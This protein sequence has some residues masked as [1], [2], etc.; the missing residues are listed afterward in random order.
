VRS[1]LDRCQN[2]CKLD[3]QQR[4]R[5]ADGAQSN[6]LDSCIKITTV[7]AHV[8]CGP[9]ASLAGRV[10]WDVCRKCASNQAASGARGA[11]TPCSQSLSAQGAGTHTASFNKIS[12]VK[13]LCFGDSGYEAPPTWWH[14]AGPD[15]R[16]PPPASP[17]SDAGARR[18]ACCRETGA[19]Q[20]YRAVCSVTSELLGSEAAADD[21]G[22][23]RVEQPMF[24]MHGHAALVVWSSRPADAGSNCTSMSPRFL[25]CFSRRR[26][27]RL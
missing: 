3:C 17:R 22:L 6:T 19:Q 20:G 8:H 26:R 14:Q 16:P 2:P 21:S 10:P 15:S 27:R 24:S 13:V 23:L 9:T 12:I 1:R 25:C 4:A 18:R 7:T 11:P 5:C